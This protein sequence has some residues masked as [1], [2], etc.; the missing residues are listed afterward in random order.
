MGHLSGMQ[1][2]EVEA[3]RNMAVI[4]VRFVALYNIWDG[5]FNLI[6]PNLIDRFQHIGFPIGDQTEWIAL[7]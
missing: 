6:G 5:G 2:G 4:L 7:E 1:A 3:L